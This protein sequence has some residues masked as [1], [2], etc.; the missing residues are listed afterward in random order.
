MATE[1]LHHYCRHLGLSPWDPSG[2]RTVALGV[3][4]TAAIYNPIFSY[5]YASRQIEKIEFRT[6][7]P[8]INL[9]LIGS[10]FRACFSEALS[11]SI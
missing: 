9:H 6:Q 2:P 4:N 1:G 5:D 11:S 8:E 3:C 7:K 10:N